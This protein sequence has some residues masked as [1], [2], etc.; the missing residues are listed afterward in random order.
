MSS[1]NSKGA[2]LEDIF[3]IL[4]KATLDDFYIPSGNEKRFV[5]NHDTNLT[6][7]EDKYEDKE[8]AYGYDSFFDADGNEL[9]L[10]LPYDKLV[11]KICQH[12]DLSVTCHHLKI[13]KW[14]VKYN[15]VEIY[16][17]SSLKISNLSSL[18]VTIP[19]EINTFDFIYNLCDMV[20][21][22]MN[23]IKT[24]WIKPSYKE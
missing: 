7:T 1:T 12:K 14:T 11:K 15:D 16:Y 6:I 24:I 17:I 22:Y 21:D 2:H 8:K 10:T 18:N 20:N 9:E 5:Y 3:H 19:L 13:D 4:K 23:A